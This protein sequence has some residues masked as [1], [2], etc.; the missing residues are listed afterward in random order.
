MHFYYGFSVHIGFSG[1]VV[2]EITNL[3]VAK[4]IIQVET[5][6]HNVTT[7]QMGDYWRLLLPGKYLV[8]VKHPEFEIYFII[9]VLR[10]K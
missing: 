6:N 2:E 1:F 3:P 7:S 4:A 9:F 5:I 8:F 10:K